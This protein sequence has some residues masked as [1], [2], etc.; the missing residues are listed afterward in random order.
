V[1]G[2]GP[3][4]RH[5]VVIRNMRIWNVHWAF[6]PVAPSVVVDHM[7]IHNAEYALWRPVY[8]RHAYRGIDLDQITVHKE[9]AAEGTRPREAD[10]PK[11]LNPVDD[12]PP[13]TVITH[14]ARAGAGKL[15]VRG[16]TSDN[17]AVKR[18]VVN[19]K[20]ARSLAANYAQW[21]V[22]LESQRPGPVRLTAHAE[23]AAGNVEKTPHVYV[24][25]LPR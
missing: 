19:G 4:A 23:D 9:F 14:V 6:H 12:L 21:E 1:D 15:V 17:G 11:P 3:D 8:Q 5:P 24:V 16:T 7:D 2:V 20:P 18:V 22:V 10:F 13:A 25:N